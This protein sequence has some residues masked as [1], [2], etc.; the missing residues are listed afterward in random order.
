MEAIAHKLEIFEEPTNILEHVFENTEGWYGTEALICTLERKT[1]L[2]YTSNFSSSG[3]MLLRDF[4]CIFRSGLE[5]KVANQFYGE[6]MI[7]S[8]N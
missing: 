5:H 1:P 2:I 6:M 3:Y 4:D 8:A 7:H